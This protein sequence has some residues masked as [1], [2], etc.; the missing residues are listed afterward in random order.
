MSSLFNKFNNMSNLFSKLS[1]SLFKLS[2][3]QFKVNL[4]L[5]TLSIKGPWLSMKLRL[6]KSRSPN[7]N[8]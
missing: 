8:M 3:L 7:K 5:N 1:N 4:E 6:F 2:L